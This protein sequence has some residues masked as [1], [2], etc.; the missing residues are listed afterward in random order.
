MIVS[1]MYVWTV[2][3]VVV[4][5]PLMCVFE[6]VQLSSSCCADSGLIVDASVCDAVPGIQAVKGP[7]L[8]VNPAS[9]SRFMGCLCLL[10]S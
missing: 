2:F 4:L 3:P 9:P 7:S 8:R 10:H 6:S 1:G 5:N